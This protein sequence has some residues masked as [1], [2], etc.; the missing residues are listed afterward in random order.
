MKLWQQV[1]TS[2]QLEDFVGADELGI[3]D[4]VLA[5][6]I[7]VGAFVLSRLV[8]RLVRWVL[9]KFPQITNEI[10]ALIGRAAGW[11]VVLAGIVWA[12]VVIGIEMVPALM[13]IIII[14]IVTFFAGRRMMENFSAGLVLQGTPMFAAGDEIVTTAG[15]GEVREI[16]GRTVIITSPD[17]EAIHVPNQIVIDDAVTNLTDLGARRSMIEI[18]VAYGTDLELA[19]RVIEQAAAD[20]KETHPDPKP[21]AL[22]SE[23]GDNAVKFNLW[24]WHDPRILER[25]RAIDVVGR[26][27]AHALAENGIVIAFPQRT[28]WWGDAGSN[29]SDAPEG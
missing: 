13:V 2:D 27:I 9:E 5:V 3:L 14:A 11:S 1:P 6:G 12:L 20:C 23:F 25:L 21:E 16:T 28:L 10:A 29:D 18:G 19:Q 26:S 17:G 15:T 22:F 7:V 4:F 8:R 24:F